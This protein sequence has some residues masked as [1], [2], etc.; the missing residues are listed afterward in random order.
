MRFAIFMRRTQSH[1]GDIKTL[2]V[3][4]VQ[5]LKDKLVKPQGTYDLFAAV[6]S[7]DKTMMIVGNAEHLIFETDNQN[8]IVLDSLS[9]W[10]DKHSGEN[11]PPP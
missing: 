11:Q 8:S 5:G 3:L 2:P 10:I 6:K 1:C 9:S 4:M 7:D